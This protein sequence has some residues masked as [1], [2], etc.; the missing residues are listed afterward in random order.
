[1]STDLVEL[2]SVKEL[3]QLPVFACFLELDVV[4]LKAVQRELRLIV[5]ED[6]ERLQ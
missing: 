2:K 5:D 6:F 3:V 1:M 4:L